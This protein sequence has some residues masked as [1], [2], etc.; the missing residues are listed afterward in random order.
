[1]VN[2]MGKVFEFGQMDKSTKANLEMVKCMDMEL[3]PGQIKI[4]T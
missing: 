4:S 2:I 3:G 1:M